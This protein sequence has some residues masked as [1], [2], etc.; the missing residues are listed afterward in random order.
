MIEGYSSWEKR[1]DY[2]FNEVGD[3]KV[4]FILTDDIGAE[5]VEDCEWDIS[6]PSTEETSSE[7]SN[8]PTID[9][10][11]GFE[12]YLIIGAIIGIALYYRKRRI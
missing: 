2:E 9:V 7:E 6:E 12:S 11:P 5:W 10:T 8:P 3:Y 1:I 4:L